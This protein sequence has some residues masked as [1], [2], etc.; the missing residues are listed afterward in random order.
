MD[1]YEELE[2]PNIRVDKIRRTDRT[3]SGFSP[4][5][6]FWSYVSSAVAGLGLGYLVVLW[7]E[8]NKNLLYIEW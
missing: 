6:I 1:K 4:T 8:K 2:L 7:I 5:W 3:I